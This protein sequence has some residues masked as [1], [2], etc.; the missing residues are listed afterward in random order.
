MKFTNLFSSSKGNCHLIEGGG[1]KILVDAGLSGI[2]IQNELKKS[3]TALDEIDAVLLTHEHSDHMKGVGVVSR[4]ADIPVYVHEDVAKELLNK[5]GKFKEKN[6]IT[7]RENRPVSI[8]G[9]QVMGFDIPH[10]AVHPLG[11]VIRDEK[12]SMAVATDMGMID[13]AVFQNISGLE[14]VFLEAN[15]DENMLKTGPYPYNLKRRILSSYGHLS[16]EASGEMAK[17]LIKS[18]TKRIRLG[19]LSEQNNLSTLAYKTVRSAISQ[20]GAKEGMDY[21]LDV[22]N[23]YEMN[24][25]VCI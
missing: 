18:G 1:A 7:I 24:K 14:F 4:R 22:A 6:I 15:H 5:C 21:V 20:T 17:R 13:E 2:K 8:K 25:S 12:I 3:G 16:N 23:R 9:L 11:F 10:D 19:H